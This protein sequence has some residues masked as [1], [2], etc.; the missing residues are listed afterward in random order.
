MALRAGL[1]MPAVVGVAFLSLALARL[2]IAEPFRAATALILPIAT[3]TAA[4]RAPRIHSGDQMGLLFE[5]TKTMMYFNAADAAL[6]VGL[7]GLGVWLGGMA[8]A[9]LGTLAASTILLCATTLYIARRLSFRPA[10]SALMLIGLA[11]LTMATVL[12]IA[13]EPRTSCA[14]SS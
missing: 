2:V 10:T 13:P 3:L 12:A 4:L 1:L 7:T 6:P 14:R 9:A 11:T 5:R 8:G